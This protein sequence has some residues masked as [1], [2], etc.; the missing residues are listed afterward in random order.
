MSQYIWRTLYLFILI[1]PNYTTGAVITSNRISKRLG[2]YFST[3]GGNPVSCA[4]GLAVLDVIKNENLM[5]SARNVGQMLREQLNT[6][7]VCILGLVYNW[8]LLI[9]S[10][11]LLKLG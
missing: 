8:E 7:K 2:A 4:I 6:L 10:V 9:K 1:N 3:F 5:S 11:T